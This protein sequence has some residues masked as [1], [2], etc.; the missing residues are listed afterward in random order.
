MAFSTKSLMTLLAFFLG[1]IAV[2]N[3]MPVS[4]ET[5]DVFVPPIKKPHA[6][7]VWK[8]G[9]NATVTWKTK[10]APVNITNSIGMVVLAQNG[11]IFT[12]QPGGLDDPLASNFSIRL[13]RIE[14]VVPEVPAANDYQIVLFGDSGNFSPEFTIKE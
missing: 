14:F 8:I 9:H 5:R 12:S 2:A 1:L 7:T 6:G 3:S 4:L 13:G 11:S 10:D